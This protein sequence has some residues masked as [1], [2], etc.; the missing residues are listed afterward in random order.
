MRYNPYTWEQKLYL[1]FVIL[2]R[3]FENL[4]LIVY[5]FI[6]LKYSQVKLWLHQNFKKFQLQLSSFFR[7]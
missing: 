7:Y 2:G 1:T 4:V 3:I 6:K 5:Y